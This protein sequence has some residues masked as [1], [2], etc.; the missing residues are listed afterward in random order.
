MTRA[1]RL[2]V[3]LEILRRQDIGATGPELASAF[4]VN[5]QTIY[6][7]IDCL[8][9]QGH[10]IETS[11]EGFHFRSP[12]APKAAPAT[13]EEF[14]Q[15]ELEAILVGLAWIAGQ[16]ESPV[17]EAA[18]RATAKIEAMLP[19]RSAGPESVVCDSDEPLDIVR[20]CIEAERRLHLDYRD[21]KGRP[22][23]RVVWPIELYG[24]D[25]SGMIAA[26]CESRN[27]FRNFRVD[28]IQS[29]HMLDRYPMRRQTLL[30]KWQLQQ[31]ENPFY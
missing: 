1:K 26:W 10:P 24:Y 8:R 27:D 30:A 11:V 2:T 9:S 15:E 12:A 20:A 14:T 23:A 13:E 6:R 22:S 25:D 5:V 18:Q 21:A 19:P 4:G 31:D 16:E 7:D 3:L 28:R 29:L 17:A